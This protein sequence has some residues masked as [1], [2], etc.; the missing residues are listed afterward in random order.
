[1]K[2]LCAVLAT[3]VLVTMTTLASAHCGKCGKDASEA[4][5]SKLAPAWLGKADG[6]KAQGGCCKDKQTSGSLAQ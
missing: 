2:T 4:K 5:S 1:M 6:A 3:A